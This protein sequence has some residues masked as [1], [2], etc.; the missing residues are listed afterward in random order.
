MEEGRKTS[1]AYHDN[2]EEPFLS[3]CEEMWHGTVLKDTMLIVFHKHEVISEV[4][5]DPSP[6]CN[7]I[8]SMINSTLERQARSTDELLRRWI[9]VRDGK[10]LDPTSV[11]PSFSS[12]AISFTQTNPLTSGTSADGTTMPNSSAQ[13]VNHFHSRTTIEGS[14]LTFGI[15]Q[16]TMASMFG[17]GYTQTTP[18]FLMPNFT[19][20]PYTPGGNDRTYAHASGNY[21]APYSTVAYTD[22][23]PL[24]GSS[25][26]F[27][28]NHT[29]QNVTCFNAYDKPE[30]GGFGYDTPP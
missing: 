5:S 6:S 14:A 18:S 23:I 21:Q 29:Y 27:L 7:D 10:N 20:A 15:L 26:G 17:Q 19:L 13:P 12:Y 1:E 4:R 28:P 22:H 2:L 11:N 3:H 16:Q 24:P 9:E 25:L 30:A 8:Q